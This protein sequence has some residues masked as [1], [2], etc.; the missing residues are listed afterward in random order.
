LGSRGGGRWR[1][2]GAAEELARARLERE[3][4]A[5]GMYYSKTDR[6]K[7][8]EQRRKWDEERV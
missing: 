1:R 2:R 4:A 3:E 7:T 5:G 6:Q 8:L